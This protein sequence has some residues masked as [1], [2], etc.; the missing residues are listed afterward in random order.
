M[1]KAVIVNVIGTSHLLHD[2]SEWTVSV[3]DQTAIMN[4]KVIDEPLLDSWEQGR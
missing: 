4:G 2:R 3:G 1:M